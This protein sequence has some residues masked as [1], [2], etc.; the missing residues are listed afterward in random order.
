MDTSHEIHPKVEEHPVSLRLLIPDPPPRPKRALPKSRLSN[1]M[2][3][4]D[5]QASQFVK[6]QRTHRYSDVGSSS[7]LLE[8]DFKG[9]DE[10]DE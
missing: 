5:E 1:T 7:Q 9:E 4:K 3:R 8:D 6:R 10:G 2:R